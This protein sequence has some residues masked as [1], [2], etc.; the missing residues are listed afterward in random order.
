MVGVERRACC[1]LFA[2][3]LLVFAFRSFRLNANHPPRGNVTDEIGG[4]FDTM[5][6]I[7]LNKISSA[8]YRTAP[9]L[10]LLIK[11]G[12]GS[13][14]RTAIAKMAALDSRR[15]RSRLVAA[16]WNAADTLSQKRL[17]WHGI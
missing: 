4:G 5:N 2:P 14:R 3:L 9:I 7:H 15:R 16:S 10:I 6:L 1:T 11:S 13:S 12:I 17:A 8:Q